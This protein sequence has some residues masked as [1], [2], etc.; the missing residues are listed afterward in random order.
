VTLLVGTYG[1]RSVDSLRQLLAGR[2]AA[3]CDVIELRLDYLPDAASRLADVVKSSTKPVMVTCRR[4]GE[5]GA[6]DGGERLRLDLL[7]RAADVGAAWIDVEDDVPAADVAKLAGRGAKIVRS[8]HVPSLPERADDVVSR[9]L[10]LPADAAKLVPLRATAADVVRLLDL[11]GRRGEKLG[12]HV[13]NSPFSRYA[14]AAMGSLFTYASLRPG[15]L[16]PAPIPTVR[17]TVDRMRFERLRRGAPLFVLVGADVERSV[18]PDMLNRAF[19]GLGLKHVALRWSCDDPA[20]AL[21]ALERFGWAGLAVTIPHK[22]RVLEI[23]RAR[24]ARLSPEVEETGA[25]NTVLQDERGLV[26]HN[27]DVRG[28]L[29]AV[30]P[31]ASV[32]PVAKKTALVLGAGGA[33]RAAVRAAARLGAAEIVVHAR[34]ADAAS[35]LASLRRDGDPPIRVAANARDAA[36]SAPALVMQA[37]PAGGPGAAA[38]FDFASLPGRALVLEMIVAPGF[39]ANEEAAALAK[40]RVARGFHMLLHQAREQARL[41][42]GR[43]PNYYGMRAAGTARLNAAARSVVLVGLR[44]AGKTEIGPRLA[45]LLGRTFVDVDRE[46]EARA[47]RSPD[48]MIRAGEEAA[49]RAVEAEVMK[50]A[51]ARPGAVVATGGGAALHEALL[52]GVAAIWPV[53]FLDAPSEVLLARWI[54]AP[55]APL[56]GLPPAKELAR[57]RRE[58]CGVYA[59]AAWLTLD[60]SRGTPDE[61]AESIADFVDWD[62]ER[63]R[64]ATS[65]PVR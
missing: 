36:E 46:V 60:T 23:L 57:Q 26:A 34:R 22:G 3:L 53:V 2:A 52:R 33:A 63:V 6:F 10:E 38:V 12:A 5:G 25:V 27:T 40:H 48:A 15:G 30:R 9:L 18:S 54:A 58:R 61:A 24:G 8:L 47:G 35:D 20:P 11:V 62:S 51:F 65:G 19:E 45:R 59:E 13:S 17:T 14:G 28:I 49:F 1:P 42:A 21:D 4:A 7:A 56:S 39:T 64:P 29:D 41:V 31:F 50:S 43:P 55:R 44:C 37:T 16:I 32:A